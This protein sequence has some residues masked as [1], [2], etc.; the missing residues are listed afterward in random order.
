MLAPTER[1]CLVIADITG[2]TEYL[3]GSELEHAQDGR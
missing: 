1:G 2:Y 3:A